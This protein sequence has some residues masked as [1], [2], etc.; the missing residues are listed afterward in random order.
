MNTIHLSGKLSDYGCKITW[1]EQE[2]PQTSFALISEEPGRE[3]TTFKTFVPVRLVG[4]QAEY[5]AETL[6]AGDLV[7]VG[8]K[9]NYKAGKTKDASTLVVTCFAVERL[10][11]E[12]VAVSTD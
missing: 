7:L 10:T 8:G 6:E 5:W 11:A 1:T 4:M 12:A 3:G 9:L 2:K